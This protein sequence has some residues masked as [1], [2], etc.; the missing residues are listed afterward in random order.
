MMGLILQTGALLSTDIQDGAN[1]TAVNSSIGDL[2]DVNLGGNLVNGKILQVVGGVLEQVD[3]PN[4]GFTQKRSKTSS[5]AQF[6]HLNHSTGLSF[7]YDDASSEIR[8]ELD[9]SLQ[10]IVNA[11][12]A[13][14]NILI[15]DGN[16]LVLNTPAQARVALDLEVGV[17]VQGN[18]MTDSQRSQLSQFLRPTTSLLVTETI[19]FLRPLL[20]QKALP[21]A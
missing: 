20:R 19:L 18:K 6:T 10:D 5:E 21:R 14:N 15:S 4:T 13:V 3:P 16:N 1:F 7:T 12:Q 17:D 2:N 11:G 8:G 9:Q